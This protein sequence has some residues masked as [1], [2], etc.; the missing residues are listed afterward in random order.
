MTFSMDTAKW[1]NKQFG[2]AELGDKHKLVLK[3]NN[4]TVV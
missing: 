1:A 3:L 4:Q 2:H